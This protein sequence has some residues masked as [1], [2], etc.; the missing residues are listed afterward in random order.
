MK[1]LEFL[2]KINDIDP[3]LLEDRPAAEKRPRSRIVRRIA[4]AA[5]AVLLLGGTVFAVTKGVS[6]RRVSTQNGDGI[7]AS[8]GL[9]LV[10][11]SSFTGEIREVGGILVSQYETYV[12]EP[13]WS[14]FHSDPGTYR[15][16]FGSIRE[17][18][19]YIGLEGLKTPVFPYDKYEC[20]VSAHGDSEGRVDRITL[21]AEHIV[22]TDICAQEMVTI[23][24]DAAE[25]PE[26]VVNS[27]W[28]WEFPRDVEL[29][30][31]TT[32]GG[33]LCAIS[34]LR[35]QYDSDYMSLTGHLTAGSAFY[36]LNLGAV[37]REKYEQALQMLHDWAD[38]LD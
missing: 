10:P 17:A 35:P 36:E 38:G 29:S 32:P 37:P 14:S 25:Q 16:S 19:E 3:A 31:Y 2:E 22:P 34:V 24:T 6:L 12:P 23:L 15:R 20:A 1:E 21:S 13:D 27:V 30:D 8:A 26:L 18:V 11:W 7:E 33:N 28:T 5:A 9:P 4:I